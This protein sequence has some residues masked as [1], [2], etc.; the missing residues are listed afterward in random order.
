MPPA[1][2]VLLNADYATSELVELGRLS[3]AIGYRY[4]WYADVRLARE[5]YLGLAAVAARTSTLLLGPGVTDPY[6]RHPAVTASTIATFDE[7][8][9]GRAL[10]GLGIG[11]AGF[12]E[13][14]IERKLPV[15]AMREAVQMVRDL[16][17]GERVTR[18]G[19]VVSLA[20]GSLS[21]KPL[22]ARIPI[23]FATHGAQI[24]RLAGEIADGVLIANTLV[25]EAFAFYVSQLEEGMAKAG[26][27]PGSLDIGLRVEAA[28]AEDDDAAYAVMRLRA[29][30]RV[31]TQYPHWDYLEA[32]GL[33]LPEA[34]VEIAA[35]RDPTLAREAAALLP[36]EIVESMVLAG[37]PER[38]AGQLARALGPKITQVT[39]RPHCIAGQSAASVVRSFAEEVFP[40]ACELA[41]VDA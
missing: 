3:E 4:L 41:G 24:A 11:G 8:A 40:R 2:G 22:R 25:P 38:V 5:C 33:E 19:K 26:R 37:N 27:D 39:I 17:R 6:S 31:M 21:F 13:L 14:G 15:A 7:L 23:Y 18:E 16:L 9:G 29:A 12:R 1:L 28:I 10:L 20:G 32:L 35:R 30:Q 34:F 36:G